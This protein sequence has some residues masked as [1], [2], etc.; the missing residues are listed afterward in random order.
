M[1]GCIWFYVCRG[2]QKWLPPVFWDFPVDAESIE[3]TF[4]GH[5]N[6]I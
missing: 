5:G 2:Y 4:F 6:H 3:A 1:K